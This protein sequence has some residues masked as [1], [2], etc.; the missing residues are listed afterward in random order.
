MPGSHAIP[1]AVC[2]AAV[3]ALLWTAA[4]EPSTVEGAVEKYGAAAR[5]KLEALGRL[6]PLVDQAPPVVAD[7]VAWPAGPV[8]DATYDDGNLLLIH[9]EELAHLTVRMR[10][11]VRVN[12]RAPWVDGSAV[13]GLQTPAGPGVTVDPAYQTGAEKP[14]LVVHT[15]QRLGR[16]Q[17]ALVV[18]GLGHQRPQM[19]SG[20][21]YQP[22]RYA[23]EVLVLDLRG[24]SLLGGFLNLN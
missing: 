4:C 15:L 12:H 19:V 1:A 13:L 6:A 10:L 18:R 11:P 21:T 8:P 5:A 22:G 7:R 9:V 20:T 14:E 16:A 2:G 3:L 23:A 24:P 17:Y